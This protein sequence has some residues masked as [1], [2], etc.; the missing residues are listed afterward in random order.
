MTIARLTVSDWCGRRLLQRPIKKFDCTTTRFPAGM[1]TGTNGE[2]LHP[3]PP[4]D[5]M[6]SPEGAGGISRTWTATR[7]MICG[8]GSGPP[9]PVIVTVEAER[10]RSVNA[11]A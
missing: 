1:T 3:D 9:T 5:W 8:A 4:N 10:L 2:A 6:A 11:S 7:R